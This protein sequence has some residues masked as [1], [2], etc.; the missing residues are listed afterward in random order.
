MNLELANSEPFYR[1]HR[2]REE[3]DRNMRVAFGGLQ[4]LRDQGKKVNDEPTESV[5]LPIGDEPWGQF[6]YGQ[7]VGS[8]VLQSSRFL[9]HMGLVRVMSAFEDF[10]E[11][12][13]AEHTRY[14]VVTK[15]VSR[16]SRATFEAHDGEHLVPLCKKLG[17][18]VKPLDFLLP[19][20]DYFS[21][22]RNCVVHRAGRASEAM[23]KHANSQ[24]L[25]DC[26][27]GWPCDGGKSLPALPKVETDR[28]IAFMPRHAVLASI[29]CHQAAI[30]LNVRLINVLGE[31]GVV[32]MAAYHT[33]LGDD[34]I[35]RRNEK[36]A[37][38]LIDYAL[39]GRYR[40]SEFTAEQTISLL[41]EMGRW[42]QCLSRFQS[43]YS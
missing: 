14:E 13:K 16:S 4:L 28:E 19:I 33:L 3:F 32:Y 35:P 7:N 31:R 17:W 37:V 25:R 20:F 26:I 34:R 24:S 5:V 15:T 1:F 10:L 42:K 18:D 9:S 29:V 36:S 12:V 6:R 11:N 30:H 43:L 21:I 39:G 23:V 27:A 2:F 40:V 8:L 22:A 41:K 38:R